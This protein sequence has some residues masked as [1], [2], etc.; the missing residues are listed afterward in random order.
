MGELEPS[1]KGALVVFLPLGDYLTCNEAVIKELERSGADMLEFGL[2]TRLPLYDGPTIR[3]AYRRALPNTQHLKDLLSYVS[4]CS[5]KPRIMLAYTHDVLRIGMLE[6]AKMISDLGFYSLIIP[7]MLIEYP[8]LTDRYLSFS[9]EAGLKPSFFITSLFP[10]NMVK[11][12]AGLAP[13]F[14]YLGLMASTGTKLPIGAS[15]NINVARRLLGDTPMLVG[16]AIGSPREVEEYVKAGADGVVIGS[17]I[18]KLIES[19]KLREASRLVDS[20]KTT[21]ANLAR[22]P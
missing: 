18:I 21:L 14:V 20:V 17:A 13:G 19:S 16:F 10:H 1:V 5:R 8:E 7:D 15:R 6:L 4:A 9:L 3:R 11:S 12:L 2:P 22:Q